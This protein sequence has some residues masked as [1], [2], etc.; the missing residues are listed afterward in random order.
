MQPYVVERIVYDSH[1]DDRDVIERR[2]TEVR[3]AIS[4]Q[5]AEELTHMLVEAVEDGMEFAVVPGYRIA[6][7]TGTS[8]IPVEGGYDPELTIASF[9]GYAPAEDPKFIALVKI[10]KPRLDPWGAEVAAP[11]FKIIA[12]RL[13]VL[14]DVPPDN[15]RL[16]SR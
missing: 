10:D 12:E 1:G 8:Q 14:L 5:T 11:V 6:G 2:P 15:V 7:K 3:R 4:A 13:F 9:V 16:A